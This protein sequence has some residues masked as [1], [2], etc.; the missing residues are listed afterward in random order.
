MKASESQLNRAI[1][2]P[3]SGWRALLLH[4][5]DDGASRLLADRL[6]AVIGADADRIDLD[7]ATLKE[8][9]ARL[10]DEATAIA[11][12]G[13]T[14]WIRVTAS[15]DEVTA[16]VT[17]LLSAPVGCPVVIIA[18]QLRG[19]SSLLKLALATQ[20]IVA[21]ASYKPD[22]GQADAI[23]LQ[24]G[25]PLGVRLSTDAARLIADACNGERAIMLREIEKLALYLDA[26]PDRPRMAERAD[27]EAIG[28]SIDEHDS[29]ILINALFDGTPGVLA[30]ELATGDGEAIP[31]LRAVLRRGLLL[32][33]LRAAKTDSAAAGLIKSLHFKEKDLVAAQRRRW[34]PAS[35]ATLHRRAMDAEAAI[36]APGSAG[37]VIAEQDMMQLARSAERMR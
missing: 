23:A 6:A 14:R 15:G 26:G 21:F 28:A 8:D 24:I 27:V 31:T 2:K 7:G 22:A 20:E 18:G 29:A 13:G 3:D 1:E 12:F 5:P 32:A 36:K 19:T 34:S 9:P 16:A 25:R 30:G 10:P 37:E 17:A 11:M 33:R 35:L 4:G